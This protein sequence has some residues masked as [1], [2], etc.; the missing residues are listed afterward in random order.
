MRLSLKIV[1]HSIYWVVF[2]VFTLLVSVA[3]KPEQW[4]T[5]L[6]LPP[7]LIINTIWAVII[8][9]FHY[10]FVI[11][12]FEKKQLFKYLSISVLSSILLTIIMLPVHKL[13]FPA[14]S[15]LDLKFIGPPMGGTFIIA[16]SGCLVKG[17]ENWFDNIRVK[18]ELENRNLR[19]ELELLKSQVNP[20]FLF[21]ALNNIDS[22]IHKSSKDASKSLINLSDMLRYM[23]YETNTE[24]VAL[25]SEIQ[26]IQNYI[27]LQH[28]RYRDPKY[29]SLSIKYD[30]DSALIAPMLFIPF[31]ENAFKFSYNNGKMP[32]VEIIIECEKDILH[33]LCK[34]YFNA[35]FSKQQKNG[36]VGLENVKRRLELLY[37][38][39]HDLKI[40][41]ENDT[42][43][44]ELNIQL[45]NN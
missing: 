36:G 32:A 30:C 29:I 37:P 4:P 33:F 16:Q 3:P 9:Y 14:F 7:H 27:E 10:L 35:D 44:I 2:L 20:H 42:F 28:L 40:S 26:Y 31:I 34:N 12:Y 45:Q 8:F 24:R 39:K 1:I 15:L 38:Q 43:S 17:F 6:E 18:T 41:K 21:N 22:L 13:F 25:S 23:I 19:N 11:K 5:L